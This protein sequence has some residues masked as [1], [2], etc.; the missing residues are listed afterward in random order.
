MSAIVRVLCIAGSDSAGGAGI[1]A[2]LKTALALGAHGMSAVTAVTA[3]S[4][5]GVQGVWPVPVEGVRAQIRAVLDDIGAD[6]IKVG[7][8]AT[9]EIVDAVADELAEVGLPV[10]VDPVCVSK[11]GD[12]LLAADALDLLKARIM[13]TATV[14]TPNLAEVGLLAG[15]EVGDRADLLAAARAVHALG[16][17]WTLVKGGHLAGDAVDLLWD[18]TTA[19]SYAAERLDNQHTHGTG[20][21]LS[22]AI[23]VFLGQGYSVPDAVQQAKDY[24]TGAIAGG[25]A[26]GS[27]IGPVDHAWRWRETGVPRRDF[28]H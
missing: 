19:T 6:A 13:A 10:V 27:G 23:A 7:M 12:S 17:R 26:L 2:D 25:F 21:T 20:C 5:R 4:S 9:A 24:V 18:G 22:S 28:T 8:L 14:V 1:Q 11:H 3:Q 16:A 15:V